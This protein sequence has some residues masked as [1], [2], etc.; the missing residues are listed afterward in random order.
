M[1]KLLEHTLSEWYYLL[2]AFCFQ[3]ERYFHGKECCPVTLLSDRTSDSVIQLPSCLSCIKPVS[4]MW[5]F[6]KSW[7]QWHPTPALLPGKSHG[8]RSLVGYSPWGHKELDTTE[9]FYFHFS[10]SC[11]GEGNGTPL[12]YSCLENPRGGWAWWAAVYGIAESDMTEL[13]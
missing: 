10:R 6:N 12:Q 2:M 1:C 5:W 7:R 8:W 9:Q 4:N 3:F 13:T 11:I